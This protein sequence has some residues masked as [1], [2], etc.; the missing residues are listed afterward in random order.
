MVV[1]VMLTIAFVTVFTLFITPV[2]A[3][4][5]TVLVKGVPNP[6]S[7]GAVLAA[8][9]LPTERGLILQSGEIVANVQTTL[10]S[11][12]TPKEILS[13]LT[14]TVLPETS[15]LDIQYSD[16][17]AQTAADG[18]NAFADAYVAFH[19]MQA[20]SQFQAAALAIQEQIRGIQ[21]E[22]DKLQTR[23]QATSDPAT[24]TQ[25]ENQTGAFFAQLGV[26]NQRLLD[27]TSAEGIAQTSAVVVQ[28]APVPTDPAS[29]SFPKNLAAG[30]AGGLAIAVAVAFLRDRMDDRLTT[31]EGFAAILG[32]PILALV[33]HWTSWRESR[34]TPLVTQADPSSAASEAY[35]TLAT[36]VQ[37]LASQQHVCVLIV[38]SAV[39]GEGKTVTSCNL[40]VVL[41]QAGKRVTLVSADLRSPRLHRFFDLE[42]EFGVSDLEHGSVTHELTAETGMA[43]LRV[44]NAGPTPTNPV[45]LLGSQGMRKLITSLRHVSDYVIVDT[46]PVLGVADV[47]VVAEFADGII[48]VASEPTST[49]SALER[50]RDQ[51]E[52][53]GAQIVGGVYNDL[54]PRRTA[55]YPRGSPSY[56]EGSERAG[57]AKSSEDGHALPRPHP[58]GGAEVTAKSSDEQA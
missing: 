18:A 39:R 16:P 29:P 23:L 35:R 38:T 19:E 32:A 1:I 13:H 43:N 25:L 52:T 8:P 12:K 14:V 42:N 28:Y 44:V 55:T 6:G 20:T 5:A 40:G 31:P 21:A 48:V 9:D 10:K 2:Y 27:L 53:A 4:H 54:D 15:L 50:A 17:A 7:S 49:A 3:A 33:P 47:L 26:L 34:T 56:Y 11:T 36:S 58:D 22:I 37:R 57:R 45:A 30:L 46:P 51:L 41:A 24:R